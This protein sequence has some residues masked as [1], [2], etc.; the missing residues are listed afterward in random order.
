MYFSFD[1]EVSHWDPDKIPQLGISC[2]ALAF[3]PPYGGMETQ[4]FSASGTFMTPSECRTLARFI[5]IH[6]MS[7]NLITW[8]GL[9]FDL[10]ILDYW[11]TRD[12]PD[13]IAWTGALRCLAENHIDPAFL[14]LAQL[15]FMIGLKAC[16]EAVG[17]RGKL[18]GMSGV[19]APS[20]WRGY[21]GKEGADMQRQISILGVE[22]GSA[23]ARQLVLD[24]VEQDAR[25]TLETYLALRSGGSIYWK[26]RAGN[27]SREPWTPARKDGD[28]LCVREANELPLPDYSGSFK[29][30]R[31]YIEWLFEN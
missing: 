6:S 28:L 29:P 19:L 8:N 15:G 17:V 4:V 5:L 13:G 10:R 24:Y 7:R 3:S 9:A 12:T 30:R 22:P 18:P 26:T 21:D 23:E 16:A 11:A 31:K 1:L 14:M 20:L 25:A 27:R 2:A